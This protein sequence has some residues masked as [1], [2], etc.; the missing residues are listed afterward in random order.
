MNISHILV[1][2]A[3]FVIA[4]LFVVLWFKTWR[5]LVSL[6]RRF[7]PVL[8]I[9]KERDQIVFERDSLMSQVK[10]QRVAWEKEFTE[11]IT[12]L[13]HLTKELALVRDQ[14]ELASFGLY[15]PQ[16][17]FETSEQ[18]KAQ[19]DKVRTNQ[20]KMVREKTA[21]LCTSE[22][23]VSGSAAKGRQMVQRYMKLQLRAFNGE[24]D[25]AVT[26][27]KYNN[28]KVLE[29]RIRRAWEAINKLGETNHCSINKDYF[30]LKLQELHL[31]HEYAEK[32]YQEQEEQRRIREQMRE[33]EKA[34][35]EYEKA[36]KEA[37]KEE[38]NFEKALDKARAELA[39]A[40]D[41]EKDTL[42]MK[43]AE[44]EAQLTEA[45]ANKERALSMAQQTKRG[46]VYVISNMGSF[47]ENVYKIGMTRRLDP[48]DRVKELGDASVPFSF[49][50]HAMLHSENAP[51]LE[52]ALHEQ[53]E[54]RRKNL[55][56]RRKEFFDVTLSEIE[57]AMHKA[58]PNAKI[59]F[60]K[61]AE[62]REYRETLALREQAQ[63]KSSVAQEQP[64]TISDAK[65]RLAA[66]R[67]QWSQEMK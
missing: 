33:E 53:F 20:K 23:T 8:D 14:A 2:A 39:A 51:E 59:E 62:A 40:D 32:K 35:R 10:K 44:L 60:T 41:R 49:D 21:A 55:V 61:A 64:P 5:K 18:Y 27:I 34:R 26:Q 37:E 47:G 65:A 6:R 54:V 66:R 50:V 63:K 9:E 45:H 25:A 58:Y 56:N 57:R 17:D 43:L 7:A 19:L 1:A 30:D 46:H 28:A 13:E 16:Y 3:G 42:Q 24:C 31:G 48:M 52:N 4:I 11:T 22:W 29:E 12:E 15:E 36:Q 67:E 38:R